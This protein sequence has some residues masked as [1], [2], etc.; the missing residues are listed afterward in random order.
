MDRHMEGFGTELFD[1]IISDGDD[2]D[3]EFIT[4]ELFPTEWL[5]D[6]K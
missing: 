3:N 2:D 4:E 6:N 5:E 1:L